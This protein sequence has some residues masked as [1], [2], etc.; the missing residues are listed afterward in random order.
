[1]EDASAVDLDWFGE[2]GHSTDY[3]DI[4]VKSVKKLQF[5]N[6]IPPKAKAIIDKY[7]ITNEDY[8]FV[9]LERKI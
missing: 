5:T 1:M 9:F 2:A 6:N 3:V 7:G 8:P 4:G